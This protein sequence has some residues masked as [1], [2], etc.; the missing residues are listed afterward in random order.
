MTGNRPPVDCNREN[1]NK[2]AKLISLTKNITCLDRV[3]RAVTWN[4]LFI[5][6]EE[7]RIEEDLLFTVYYA[8]GS[9]GGKIAIVNREL[10]GLYKR[11]GHA[12]ERFL[13]K[14]KID[15]E[16]LREY[17]LKNDITELSSTGI[18]DFER[19]RSSHSLI[20]LNHTILESP[21]AYLGNMSRILGLQP[22]FKRFTIT[23]LAEDFEVEDVI[24]TIIEMTGKNQVYEMVTLAEEIAEIQ[25]ELEYHREDENAIE[26]T[27]LGQ[28]IAD[29]YFLK[30]DRERIREECISN[31]EIRYSE[32]I[33]RFMNLSMLLS[34]YSIDVGILIKAS[35]AVENFMLA[36][37]LKV[38]QV[39]GKTYNFFVYN[40]KKWRI[41]YIKK[42]YTRDEIVEIFEH[43]YEFTYLEVFDIRQNRYVRS[44]WDDDA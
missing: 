19:E 8:L 33:I 6:F 13:R 21:H 36:S 5:L 44:D 41:L 26:T 31:V 9:E 2:I 39:A 38:A 20:N 28:T 18:V 37:T 40:G 17:L 32:I 29:D 24:E 15:Y 12:V 34:S 10:S 22:S 16:V 23:A 27:V 25:D 7:Y 14:G 43:E 3:K 1:V 4:S 35:M 11:Q 42:E 30:G